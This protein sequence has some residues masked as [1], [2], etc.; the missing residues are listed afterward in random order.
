MFRKPTIT[1][2]WSLEAIE[3]MLSYVETHIKFSELTSQ[4]TVEELVTLFR[5]H[6]PDGSPRFIE[7]G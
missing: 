2:G 6:N 5:A 4:E 7:E 3:A 1:I